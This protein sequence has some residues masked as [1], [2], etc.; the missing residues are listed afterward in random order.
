MTDL[1]AMFGLGDP[2]VNFREKELERERLRCVSSI[3]DNEDRCL[4]LK[5]YIE[6]IVIISFFPIFMMAGIFPR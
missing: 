4:T 1:G 5:E 2:H 6:A 3:K